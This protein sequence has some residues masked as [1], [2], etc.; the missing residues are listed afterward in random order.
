MVQA[1]CKNMHFDP[2]SCS[3]S[4]GNEILKR[5]GIDCVVENDT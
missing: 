3:I 4:I 2:N 1:N 5:I